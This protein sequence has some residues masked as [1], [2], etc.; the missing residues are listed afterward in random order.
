MTVIIYVR[1]LKKNF[2][3][4]SEPDN[5]NN[6]EFGALFLYPA[7]QN[8]ITPCRNPLFLSLFLFLSLICWGNEAQSPAE[9]LRAALG[10]L[11]CKC[12]VITRK[13]GEWKHTDENRGGSGERE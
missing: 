7:I 10:T 6:K 8:N 13:L 5:E 4:R 9:E 2:F 12:Q 3:V 1:K 11:Q